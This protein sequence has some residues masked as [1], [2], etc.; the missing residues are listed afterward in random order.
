M[1][2]PERLTPEQQIERDWPLHSRTAR[3][4]Q[5]YQTLDYATNY[6]K[7]LQANL[8]KLQAQAAQSRSSHNFDL[9][10]LDE[11]VEQMTSWVTEAGNRRLEIEQAIDY[12]YAHYADDITA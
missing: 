1:S 9:E 3:I 12:A 6:E 2:T 4:Q 11:E 8:L 7:Q 5:L 10:A